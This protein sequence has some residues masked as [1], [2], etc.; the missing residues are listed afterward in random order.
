MEYF[1][2]YVTCAGEEEARR[3]GRQAVEE[4]LAACAN[5]LGG[6]ESF[7]RWEGKLQQDKEWALLLKT[8]GEKLEHLVARVKDLH[9][10]QVP[11]IVAWPIPGGFEPYLDWVAGEC[12]GERISPATK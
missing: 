3:I 10:Y 8:T 5:L 1:S 9:S 6:I 11:C 4:R 7:Y 2:V 12:T